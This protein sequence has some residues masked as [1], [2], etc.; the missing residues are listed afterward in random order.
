MIGS[1]SMATDRIWDA[2]SRIVR[3]GAGVG[4][5][6]AN[7]DGPEGTILGFYSP[8]TSVQAFGWDLAKGAIAILAL[9]LIY[10]GIQPKRMITPSAV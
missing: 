3:I 6:V 1:L 8:T 4:I 7:A 5:L 2:V 10:R 9:W